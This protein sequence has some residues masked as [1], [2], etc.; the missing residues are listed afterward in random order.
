MKNWELISV[1]ALC[2]LIWIAI[3]IKCAHGETFV[4]MPPSYA[5]GDS[6]LADFANH[7]VPVFKGIAPVIQGGKLGKGMQ[8]HIMGETG[9]ETP[10]TI[11]S[12]DPTGNYPGAWIYAKCLTD[13][14]IMDQVAT[15]DSTYEEV[16]S[17]SYYWT[18]IMCH[19]IDLY[20]S[21]AV[22]TE[23]NGQQWEFALENLLAVWFVERRFGQ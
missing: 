2:V 19:H 9:G 8:N 14:E 4:G 13:V 5:P 21:W 11:V 6:I 12:T 7:Q 20:S 23:T 17:G 22:L 3:G 18:G 10:V 15:S 16:E 1:L